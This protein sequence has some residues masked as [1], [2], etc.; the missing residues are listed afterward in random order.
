MY[1]LYIIIIGDTMRKIIAFL[2]LI[3]VMI[4]IFGINK[5]IS[6]SNKSI[7]YNPTIVI[8][9]GHGGA[10]AGAIAID[11]ALEKDINLAIALNLYDY[12]M[13]SGYNSVLIR[14]GDYEIYPNGIDRSRSDLY[15]RMDYINSIN[16]SI[17]ISIHQNHF[18]NEAEQGTQI[19]YSANFEQSKVMADSILSTVKELLQPNNNRVNKESDSSYYLLYKA[20]CPSIM[21]E[22]GFISNLK[23][24]LCLQNKEYQSN[25]AYAIAVGIYEVI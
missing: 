6:I 8:D 19:W 4:S 21:I 10:D 3:I 12:L 13:I 11:G 22:C 5:T 16:N 18:D 20:K 7:N 15:N 14:N 17:L 24:N 23:E 9:A 2:S 25:M 1:N